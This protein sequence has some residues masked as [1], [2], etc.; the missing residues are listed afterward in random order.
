MD[1]KTVSNDPRYKE[2]T[3]EIQTQIKE[4]WFQKNIKADSR[5]KPSLE[6]RIRHDLFGEPIPNTFLDKVTA[7]GRTLSEGITSI[8]K[9]WAGGLEQHFSMPSIIDTRKQRLES[10]LDKWTPEQISKEKQNIAEVENFLKTEDVKNQEF[11]KK[12]NELKKKYPVISTIGEIGGSVL[13]YTA[14]SAMGL[15][16][17]ASFGGLGLLREGGRQLNTPEEKLTPAQ[18][19]GKVALAG[20]ADA[21]MGQIFKV[22]DQG[23]TILDRAL[24][25]AKGSA[26]TAFS[27]T[28]ADEFV[29][30]NK[31]PDLGKAVMNAGITAATIGITKL[32]T[33][34]PEMRGAIYSEAEA[35]ATRAN[36]PVPKT[37][38]EAVDLVQEASFNPQEL[39]PTFRRAKAEL[40]R[41]AAIEKVKSDIN[42]YK[43]KL[44]WSDA[45]IRDFFEIKS[46]NDFDT[47][48]Y[49]Y[50]QINPKFVETIMPFRKAIAKGLITPDEI[51]IA[52]EV[53][54]MAQPQTV[55]EQTIPQSQ[56]PVETKA[57]VKS[58]EV[59]PAS[60]AIQPQKAQKSAVETPIAEKTPITV[61]LPPELTTGEHLFN[62]EQALDKTVA[63]FDESNWTQNDIFESTVARPIQSQIDALNNQLK[64][65]KG[66]KGKEFNTAR[67]DINVKLDELKT[68]LGE[69]KAVIENQYM[70]WGMKFQDIVKQKAKESGLDLEEDEMQNLSDEVTMS[71]SEG[72]GKERYWQTKIGDVIDQT[73]QEW[74]DQASGKPL[75]TA[76]QSEFESGPGHP[77]YYAKNKPLAVEDIEPAFFDEESLSLYIK[78][79]KPDKIKELLSKTKEALK[80]DIERYQGLLKEG[81]KTVAGYDTDIASGGDA[82][83]ALYTAISLKHNHISHNKGL[84]KALEDKLN[85]VSSEVIQ[86]QYSITKKGKKVLKEA[87]LQKDNNLPLES[88]YDT[89][90]STEKNITEYGNT[91]PAEN[92]KKDLVRFAKALADELGWNPD[93]TKKGKKEIKTY[94]DVNVAPVGGDGHILLWKPNSEFGIYLSFDVDRDVE[95][96]DSDNLKVRENFMY[97]A[98]TK[99]D[100]W[101]GKA[102]NWAKSDITVGE[103]AKLAEKEVSFYENPVAEK[104]EEEIEV[105]NEFSEE[106]IRKFANTNKERIVFDYINK[107]GNNIS[108][109]KFK[110]YFKD[111]GYDRTDSRPY[112]EAAGGIAIEYLYRLADEAKGSGNQ[113]IFTA[114]GTGSGKSSSVSEEAK[115]SAVAVFDSM[116]KHFEKNIKLIQDMLDRGLKVKVNFVLR[117]PYHA[118]IDGVLERALEEKSEDYR[119]IVAVIE[120]VNIHKDSL[121]NIFKLIEH[122]GDKVEFKLWDNRGEKGRL[123]PISLDN[124]K[125]VSYDYLGIRKE[126]LDYVRAEETI[127]QDLKAAF[128]RGR[129]VG[130]EPGAGE[131]G[132]QSESEVSRGRAEERSEVRDNQEVGGQDVESGSEIPGSTGVVSG[133]QANPEQLPG[134]ETERRQQSVQS[135]VERKRSALNNQ[136]S[137]EKQRQANLGNYRITDA[138]QIGVG[139]PKEKYRNNVQAI[140]LLKKIESENRKATPEEQAVLI[141][142]VGWGGLS[143][144][145]DGWNSK[146]WKKEYDEISELLTDEEYTAARQSTINAHYTSPTVIR[147]I[148]QAV[149]NIG[150]K[151]GKVLEPAMGVGHFIGLRPDGLRLAFTGIELDSLTGRIAQQLYQNIDSHIDA[152]EK[153]HL[154]KDFYDLAISNVPFADYKPFDPKYKHLAIPQNLMLHDY[155]FA[156]SLAVVKPGGIVAFITSKGTMDKQDPKLREWIG[157][158]A[159]LLGA[160]RLPSTAFKGNAGT[161]VVT[162]ILFLRKRLPGEK[163]AGE[164]WKASNQTKISNRNININQYFI[165]NTAMVLGN[166]KVGKGLYSDQ[167][168]IVDPL[169]ESLEDSLVGAI[170]FLP[171]DVVKEKVDIVEAQKAEEIIPDSYDTKLNAYVLKEGKIYQKTEEGLQAQS[172]SGED[173]QRISGMIQIRNAARDVLSKQL[174]NPDDNAFK[175]DMS[176]LNTLYDKF[177]KK[178]GY[179]NSKKNE[180]LFNEDPDSPLL[181]S[182]ETENKKN[183]TFSKHDIFSKRVT[184]HHIVPVSADSA[185]DAIFIS[186]SEYGHLN[187]KYISS[188]LDNKL[189][190]DI[191]Q[192]LSQEGL[193][194]K[195]PEGEK[196]EIS[197]EYLSGNVKLKLKLAEAAVKVDPVY[198]RNIEELKKVIPLD[199]TFNE[200]AVRLGSPWIEEDDYK[201]F[202]AELLDINARS[203]EVEHNKVDGRWVFKLTGYARFAAHNTDKW[204]SERF[205]GIDLIE[206]IANHRTIVVKDKIKNDLGEDS[207]VTN[208]QETEVAQDKAE[209]L[210]QKFSD[211][212]WLDETRRDKYLKIYNDNYNNTVIRK[213]DGSHLTLPGLSN[214]YKLRKTQLDA[215]WRGV[216]SQSLMLAHEVGAG[217]T[218]IV[219]C[220]AMESKRLGLINKPIIV[221]PRNTLSQWK[222]EFNKLYPA[223]NILV[224]DER[225][226]ITTRRE[227]FLGKVATGNYDAIIF[228][229]SSN[230]LVGVSNEAYEEYIREQID[231]LRAELGRQKTSGS[232]ISIKQIEK[233]ILKKEEFLKKKLDQ[234]DK[235][236]AVNFEEL[237]VDAVFVDEAD[238]FKNLAY[239]TKMENIRG[240]GDPSGNKRTEDLMMKTRI[241]R[242]KSGKIVF[243][244]GT[245]ISNTMAEVHSMM[246][247]LQPDILEEK[248]LKHFDDWA[249][250]FGE[251]V[252]TLEV[253]AT[254][255]RYK[256]VS[257]FSKFVNI[258][259]LLQILHEVWDIQTAE[260][261]EEQGILVKG[262]NLPL[263]KGGK[264]TPVV[265]APTPELQAYIQELGERA[266]KI[267]GKRAEKGG[268]NMLVILHD[269]IMASTDMRMIDPSF[270]ASAESKIEYAINGIFQ[271]WQDNDSTKATQIIFI[272]RVAPNKAAAFNPHYY[273]IRKLIEM[274]VPEKEIALIHDY[275]TM[276]K[277][278]MLYDSVNNGEVRILFGSTEK[279]GA[280]T[281]VQQRLVALWHLDT[282]FRPRDIMQREGRIVRPGNTNK[283]I[284]IL[285]LVTK[286]S[287][288]T[289]MWQ[290]L[291]AKAKSINQVMSGNSKQRT[292]EEDVDEYAIIK[293]ASSDN[294]LLKEKVEV[295]KEV[296]RLTNLK[297]AFL[298]QKF[299]SEKEAKSLPGDIKRIEEGIASIKRDISA[300]P[301]KMTKENFKVEINDK[302]FKTKEEAWTE[303]KKVISGIT[304]EQFSRDYIP[305]G[306]YQG[307]KLFAYINMTADRGKIP[308]IYIKGN[309]YQYEA[310]FSE[311][312]IGTFASLDSALYTQ[313]DNRLNSLENNLINAQKQLKLSIELSQNNFEH[314][315]KLE[316]KSK[317]QIEINREL[318][319]QAEGKKT[320]EEEP[321][322]KIVEMH[323]GIPIIPTKIK[324]IVNDKIE[325]GEV[326]F[327]DPETERRFKEASGQKHPDAVK[328]KIRIFLDEFRHRATRVYPQLPN[329]PAYSFFREILSQ[330]QNNRKIAQESTMRNIDEITKGFGPN[331]LYLFTQ[332]I[333][334]ADLL[335]EAEAGRPIPFGYSSYDEGGNLYTDMERLIQ[336][337]NNIDDRVRLNPDIAQAIEKRKAIWRNITNQLVH[338]K[339]LTPDQLKEDYFRHQILDCANTKA[340]FGVGK[341]LKT[342]NPGY[343]KRRFGSAEHDINTNYLEAEFEVMAQALH[344]IKTAQN[345]DKIRNSPLNIKEQL[346]DQARAH[347]EQMLDRIVIE[348]MTDKNGNPMTVRDTLKPFNQ[349]IGYGF[350]ILRDLGYEFDQE[351]GDT[352][353]EL[354]RIAEDE[355]V[356][357]RARIA[358]K[359]ILKSSAD[360]RGAIKQGLGKEFKEWRDLIPTTHKTWQPKEGRIFF[361]A[362]SVSQRIVDNVLDNINIEGISK[363]DI[364]K[365]LAVGQLREEFVLPIDVIDTLDNLYTIKPENFIEQG[366][367]F[368]TTQWKKWVLFNPRRA[369][370]YNYQ[371]FLGDV[372]AVIAGQPKIFQRFVQANQE[373]IDVFYKGKTMSQSMREFFER[374][375]LT[376]EMTIQEIP[377]INKLELFDRF[378]NQANKAFD[379]RNAFGSMH[380]YWNTV[381]E[382]TVYRESILRYASYLYYRDVFTSGQSE[383]GA[384]IRK[385]I[386][387]LADP[388]D[389]AAKVATELLGDYQNI[390]ALGKDIRQMV[391]PFYSWLEIN[392]KRYKRLGRNAFDEGDDEGLEFIK[393]AIASGSAKTTILGGLFVT[394]WLLRAA[395]LTMIVALYNQIF[396]RDEEKDLNLYDQ[397]RM[398]L[399]IGRDRHGRPI[400][401]RGQGAFSDLL[402]WVGLNEAP[403]LWRDYF[404]G[405]SSLLD[406]LK[407]MATAGPFKLARGVNPIYKLSAETITG[408][409]V[410]GLDERSGRIE[411]KTR[412]VF[413]AL[414]LENEYDWITKKPSR[415]YFKTL[416]EAFITTTEP[417]ENAFRYIQGEKH[418]YLEK[419]GKGGTG[420]YYTPRSI[421]YR[422]Y[423]KALVFKDEAARVN[424]IKEMMKLGVKM[425]DL[426]RSIKTNDPLY[427]LKDREKVDFVKN[428]LTERD[429][430]LLRRAYRYYIKT[431]LRKEIQQ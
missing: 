294:P 190:E 235:D 303:I 387:G 272:D 266:D 324:P 69:A 430:E 148:W 134:R 117:N 350:S 63:E 128:L 297:N 162:D 55:A 373:L 295:D 178:Y 94:A 271:R 121:E 305:L 125:S 205:P 422:Q 156:K 252:S 1:W 245:P 131:V 354:A 418:K 308:V 229:D 182:L 371:N 172:F 28:I 341:K 10:N 91:K 346:K 100:K 129:A 136:E 276:E 58:V 67:K 293:A 334:L 311:S 53:N 207:Y 231:E 365:I 179:L 291:E 112:Q 144:V 5:F 213:Y 102:N 407:K 138:D 390:T 34:I 120:H 75:E 361:S 401:L 79:D 145:F 39:S 419:M 51:I 174:S 223:A 2:A 375:G 243:A 366:A 322:E 33:E 95:G 377:E 62:P 410:L 415:G 261:L 126:L 320:D 54:K 347:N 405:K 278:E 287:L 241:I 161:E 413:K 11:I 310:T 225:N 97:R 98:T 306:K 337:K 166:M 380:A 237:G 343:A 384:S 351:S 279:L 397:N 226:F 327:T 301:V 142:Y 417:E 283:E 379:L 400:I 44:G 122:F 374:G 268:D 16:L 135:K 249:N 46:I 227:K 118:F 416:G 139:S 391:I 368:L 49:K 167:E 89:T 269:G 369:F 210:K 394:K 25:V 186:L 92:F 48:A 104:K 238:R 165:K 412:N 168:L 359:M 316:D 339:I 250:A 254:G 204:G 155:F 228:A 115:K 93:I 307:F 230:Y 127:P 175:P 360:K 219:V 163:P 275:D 31:Q 86:E 288:D 74:K 264:A 325:T 289:F 344:D 277:K 151:G 270:P 171:K 3:P 428:F 108:T 262:K 159:D 85:G 403:T 9:S 96:E 253:D 78:S 110:E 45:N 256:S 217:K 47:V 240:L 367:K 251:V 177:V 338:Y 220:I 340:T 8:P 383:Y 255:G 185:K 50:A 284:E 88:Y 265:I 18:R 201:S 427:G 13:P 296:R 150:F 107:H 198:N 6:P 348:G 149:K 214:V 257:R 388:L 393:R 203:V 300:R 27:H 66:K 173:L 286:G 408:K 103:M 332:A 26:A 329:D 356:E 224:A 106:D 38:K 273:M 199:L 399:V 409:T 431:F 99:K 328:H 357:E 40:T 181:L 170:D 221:V 19:T 12:G 372:D 194:F 20:A 302:E 202:V 392:F 355:E 29:S 381:T 364:R 64:D 402:E 42:Y 242:K 141:K 370:K 304:V 87:K 114:G 389:K 386:D 208:E 247:Y 382:F 4:D 314:E 17:W 124:L 70:D 209:I 215:I 83:L 395:A 187:W 398:H 57:T 349:K 212:F 43:G 188:L 331:K 146:D 313:P 68:A 37:Y 267:K 65:L 132:E 321:P 315:K 158:R 319:K 218:A 232:R 285:R 90:G 35:L 309:S 206:A 263:I 290:M 192:E 236:K 222:R 76:P 425:D 21:I 59:T 423:K 336:D 140:K 358:A 335:K 109:D 298:E 147:A 14:A 353:E 22:A 318:K 189:E 345:I 52:L 406:I 404:D 385:E 36:K 183:K 82:N 281:N 81:K 342:P 23:K 133:G 71:I 7:F 323:A 239:T 424:A 61:N 333:I 363:D 15:P 152:F 411:D 154:S 30:G 24:S 116:L 193:I 153:T 246:K 72:W 260:M 248:G 258:P 101:G 176:R 180:D 191:Q 196:W 80:N 137:D 195:N 160:I 32:I 330:Q 292:I 164:E 234:T 111:V 352:F 73:I 259:E 211:W 244:T 157:E 326:H 282:P 299:K 200:I 312:A 130:D 274:G 378:H 420:D 143:K 113:I 421:L 60:K 396:H 197:D 56:K 376:T 280:G 77:W 362:I 429:R 169:P 426:K 414:Q 119:R 233:S 84:I 105:K 216:S 317:R 184:H 41:E 123:K